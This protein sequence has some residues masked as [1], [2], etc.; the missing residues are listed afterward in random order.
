MEDGPRRGTKRKP[1]S[2]NEHD[3]SVMI[4]VR[5]LDDMRSRA[6]PRSSPTYHYASC[7][8]H[9]SLLSLILSLMCSCFSVVVQLHS[10]HLPYR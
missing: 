4:A 8:L 9:S 7:A 3:E 1:L 10:R 5:A 6:G 2:L